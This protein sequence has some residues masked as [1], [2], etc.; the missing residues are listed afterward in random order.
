MFSLPFSI[1]LLA[2]SC[3]PPSHLLCLFIPSSLPLLRAPRV[4]KTETSLALMVKP[5]ARRVLPA[6]LR[7]RPWGA[8]VP[9]G[10]GPD[11]G[12]PNPRHME[13]IC[14]KNGI[15][16]QLQQRARRER[17]GKGSGARQNWAPPC[18]EAIPS[19]SK[20]SQTSRPSGPRVPFSVPR[21]E[22]KHSQPLTPY[23]TGL[24]TGS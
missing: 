15:R 7:V 14:Q 1:N 10:D 21:T 8:S 11:E 22:R 13:I 9:K 16:D 23:S 24:S 2:V 17:G 20:L 5:D 19:P 6:P 18:A 3:S 12:K 4:I